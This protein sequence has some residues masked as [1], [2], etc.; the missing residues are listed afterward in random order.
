MRILT[1][2]G[3]PNQDEAVI[4]T[5]AKLGVNLWAHMILLTVVPDNPRDNGSLDPEIQKRLLQARQ[6]FLDLCGPQAPYALPELSEQAVKVKPG[7]FDLHPVVEKGRK[8]L[9]LQ[10]RIGDLAREIVDHAYEE[11]VDLI[12]MSPPDTDIW[13]CKDPPPL[14]QVAAEAG[15]STLM[16]KNAIQVENI[17]VGLE[18]PRLNQTARE[19]FAQMATVFNAPAAMYPLPTLNR[20]PGEFKSAMDKLVKIFKAHDLNV[21]TADG[22][23]AEP[24]ICELYAKARHNMLILR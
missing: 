2:V 15:C 3:N 6:I 14:L 18:N 17:I 10:V 13:S 22:T 12:I 9:K 19:M 20:N 23:A 7:Q 21:V 5:A 24:T 8:E 4:Q 1:L 16:I 11:D